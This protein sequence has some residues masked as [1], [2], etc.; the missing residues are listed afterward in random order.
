M[1]STSKPNDDSSDPTRHYDTIIDAWDHL[2]GEDLHYGFF[3]DSSQSLTTA[4]DALT[5]EMLALA[6][7]KS[8]SSVLDIGCGTGKAGCR[9]ASEF[10]CQLLGVSPSKGC[11]NRASML[12]E[13]L[14]LSASAVFRVGDGTKL[15]LADNSFDRVWVM[16]SSHLMDDKPALLRECARVVKPGGRVVLC[17]V[18]LQ[19]KLDIPQVIAHRDEFLI[20]KA[21]FGRAKMET[22]EFYSE[23]LEGNHLQVECARNIT[24]ETL[25]T[26]AR[27]RENAL[28]NRANVEHYI[29]DQAWEHFLAS[30]NVLE[31]FW[32]QNIMG[33]GIISA[34]KPADNVRF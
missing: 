17:D 33:Y 21:A 15:E 14:K 1:E 3:T 28:H 19:A 27:W 20:L 9:I 23:Q 16:E 5:N 18:M 6:Q 8:G 22:L 24:R 30:C 4:T 31:S 10:N 12:A 2:L 7:L 32:Q 29:G 25:P 13:S 11:V 26:F 34:R